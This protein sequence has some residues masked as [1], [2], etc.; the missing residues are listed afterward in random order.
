MRYIIKGYIE[1]CI[2]SQYG[3]IEDI[4]GFS[5]D[6]PYPMLLAMVQEVANHNGKDRYR[7][8]KKFFG[9]ELTFSRPYDTVFQFEQMITLDEWFAEIENKTD[10]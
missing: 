10:A 1:T 3:D 2:E 4:R 9:I 8:R 5:S 6:I 7:D